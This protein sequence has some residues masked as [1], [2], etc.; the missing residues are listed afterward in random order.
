MSSTAIPVTESSQ[1]GHARR[2]AAALAARLGF[3]EEDQGKVAL[4]VS[5]AA[6]NLVAHAREGL[7]LLRALHQGS[8]VGLEMLALDKG[9][10]MADVDRCLRDGYS[11]AGTGGSG[12]GAMRRMSALFDVYSVPGVGTA[13]LAWLWAGKPPPRSGMELGVVCVPMAGEEVCGDSWAVDGKAGRFLFLVA[14]GLGHGPEAA[15]ASRAAVVSFLEQGSGDPVELLRGGHQEL[16]S[17]RGAAV[18]L[19]ALTQDRSQLHYAG[20]GNISA[21]VVSPGDT[22]RLVSMN[23]TLGHQA[24]RMQQ[25]SYPW[26]AGATLVMCSDGL[27][28]QWRLDAYP[29]LLTRHPG[30]VAGVLYRDFARGRDDATVLV[31]REVPTGESR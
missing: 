18:A 2:T 8:Q 30:L 1:A 25:F 24:P 6:K 9:P 21:S 31:A 26:K 13:V 28:T 4:V 23:G 27:A 11:T 10:G 19:A 15:R 12:L 5:E 17:T 3:N 16:R 22:Q 7:I 20:V 29:G 14:D